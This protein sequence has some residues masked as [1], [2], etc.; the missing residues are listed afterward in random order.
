MK[1]IKCFLSSLFV[2][3][4][5]IVSA[6]DFAPVVQNVNK[7]KEV[8]DFMQVR[9][10]L[11]RFLMAQPQLSLATYYLAYV[12]IK[13]SLVDLSADN[14]EKYLAEAETCLNKLSG[15]K[16]I[17]KSEVLTLKGLRLYAL[18][19]S[20]PQT[21]GP[22]YSGEIFSLY[23]TALAL[24]PNNPRPIILSALFKYDMAKYLH[25]T[26]ESFPKD[27][28]KASTLFAAQDSTLLTPTW[29]KNWVDFALSKK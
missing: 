11:E 20:N 6:Q 9:S 8:S 5:V 13:L 18:M 15:M 2:M 16:D 21:N 14:K 12:D 24:N 10:Q 3:L 17:D 7:A 26:Y 28:E 19:A 27:I 1:S 23:A 4:S 29:G 22:K 25:Q